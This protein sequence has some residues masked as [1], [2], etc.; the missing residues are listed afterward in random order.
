VA[1]EGPIC[2]ACGATVGRDS[3]AAPCGHCGAPATAAGLYARSELHIKFDP[4]SYTP[5]DLADLIDAVN[6]SIL[7]LDGFVETGTIQFRSRRLSCRPRATASQLRLS[8]EQVVKVEVAWA[9]G[10]ASVAECV[11]DWFTGVAFF[12]AEA[13]EVGL[14][15]EFFAAVKPHVPSDV[16]TRMFGTTGRP[17][18]VD[19]V[20]GPETLTKVGEEQPAYRFDDELEQLLDSTADCDGALD[21]SRLVDLLLKSRSWFRVDEERSG[22]VPEMLVRDADLIGALFESAIA[23][24]HAMLSERSELVRWSLRP[25]GVDDLLQALAGSPLLAKWRP[26][27]RRAIQLELAARLGPPTTGLSLEIL[28]D[29]TRHRQRTL[30]SYRL[31]VA[32]VEVGRRTTAVHPEG[33]TLK[34]FSSFVLGTRAFD[35]ANA[36][37]ASTIAPRG[38]TAFIDTGDAHP[39][40]EGEGFFRVRH[41]MCTAWRIAIDRGDRHVDA[42]DLLASLIGRANADVWRVV[43]EY[44]LPRVEFLDALYERLESDCQAELARR[45]MRHRISPT[46]D[47]LPHPSSGETRARIGHRQ[48]T[49]ADGR[50][51][52]VFISY[53]HDSEEHRR[54]VLELVQQLRRDGIDAWLDQ[55]ETSPAQGW[56]RW[57]DEQ[58]QS[59]NFLVLVCTEPFRRHFEGRETADRYRGVKYEA[60]ITQQLLYESELDYKRLVPILLE[61]GLVE[62]IPIRIR[63]AT[64]HVLPGGYGQLRDRLLGTLSAVPAPLGGS[65]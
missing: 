45:I 30:N 18:P 55:F 2:P 23:T 31:F 33:R 58:V 14:S 32:C 54:R 12:H 21:E 6:D 38:A 62:N 42:L 28:D 56:P 63:P 22:Q 60:L 26:E 47:R 44:G 57:L 4:E 34:Q 9:Y 41:M 8:T 37:A 36:M 49:P 43:E 35:A 13:D 7:G 17:A 16:S 39:S 20:D 15:G 51:P 52:R 40:G 48:P 25:L 3:R 65:Q 1:E 61:G 50:S 27:K 64:H 24:A 5:I 11:L 59:A 19:S 46:T 10:A 53:S 29:A